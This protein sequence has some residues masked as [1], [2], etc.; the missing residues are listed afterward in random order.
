MSA[1]SPNASSPN[2][3]R[4][5]SH[6][7]A[8]LC[9]LLATALWSI[10]GSVTRQLHSAQGFEITMWR[11]VFAGFTIVVLWPFVHKHRSLVDA[12]KGGMMIW[13]P[14][15]CWAVMFSCFMIALSL[16]TVA[17]VLVAQSVGPVITALL[18][19]VWLKRKLSIRTWS[20]ILIASLGVA[21]MFV[22]DVQSLSG[23][24]WLGFII[25][26]GIPVAGAIN[27][28][29]VERYG[30]G[31]DF[32]AGIL[33][34]AIISALITLPLAL[35]LKADLHD[36]GL[37]AFLGVFQLGIPCAICVLA[38]RSLRAA[39]LSLMTLLEVIF[40]MLLALLFTSERPGM[41]TWIGGGLVVIALAV[42]ELINLG[43]SR[44]DFAKANQ[45]T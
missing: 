1:Y 7:N 43:Q 22:F 5:M 41:W 33:I 10:A 23:K 37:L 18:S 30:K 39:E 45:S 44:S 40:G 21:L 35:P 38:A 24:H 3:S 20:V 36:V 16:T 19:W 14:G 4:P 29:F 28:N 26:L 25:A 15:I 11:S 2:I 31:S 27:W 6:R 32:V 8:L 17:N 34:G 9:M 13:I 42:N 12:L